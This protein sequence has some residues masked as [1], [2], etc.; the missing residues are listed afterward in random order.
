MAIKQS[1]SVHCGTSTT[2]HWPVWDNINQSIFCK[3]DYLF[4]VFHILE[5]TSWLVLW[6][7]VFMGLPILGT[8]EHHITSILLL[9]ALH[10]WLFLQIH[11]LNSRE[12][13]A[14]QPGLQGSAAVLSSGV[15]H[16]ASAN[17]KTHRRQLQIYSNLG[18]N[19]KHVNTPCIFQCTRQAECPYT[20]CS[21]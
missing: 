14:Q 16:N 17:I 8:L 12:W 4:R 19:I 11:A 21:K 2:I 10:L 18:A 7:L 13:P 9:N 5:G 1:H 3:N 6:R 20:T 15:Q